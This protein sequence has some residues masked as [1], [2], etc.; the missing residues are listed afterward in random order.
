MAAD[1]H[2][3]TNWGVGPRVEARARVPALIGL[4]GT[5]PAIV[6][7]QAEELGVGRSPHCGLVLRARGVSREHAKVLLRP[8]TA[9]SVVDLRSRNGTFVNGR[10][11]DAQELAEGDEIHFGP[12]AAFRFTLALEHGIDICSVTK[13][14]PQL[15]GLSAR[16]RQVA[17][18][19]AQRL[20]NAQIAQQLGIKPRTVATHLEHIFAKLEIGSRA[21][22]M[23]RVL[24]A[25]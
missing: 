5:Q 13:A 2:T 21:E 8:Q 18:L 11:I 22:L 6:L 7:L 17:E 1:D 14:S 3:T 10:R 15:D 25:Q 4:Q 20:T 16:Q 24:G 23:L 19:V 9:V 12:I